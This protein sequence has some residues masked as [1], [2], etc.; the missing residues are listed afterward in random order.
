MDEV[1][2]TEETEETE[3]LEQLN[4]RRDFCLFC[5]QTVSGADENDPRKPGA[6]AEYNRQFAAIDA[7]ITALTGRPPDTVIHLKPAI[8]FPKAPKIGEK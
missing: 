5:I 4:A 7:R 3:T 2:K 1:I 6:I 8:L